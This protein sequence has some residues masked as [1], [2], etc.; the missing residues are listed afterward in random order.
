MLKSKA[1]E[2]YAELITGKYINERILG[3]EDKFID[4][5]LY[6]EI[7]RNVFEYEEFYNVIGYDL[8]HNSEHKYFYLKK[9]NE[10]EDDEKLLDKN[11]IK[12][13]VLSVCLCRFIMDKGKS[14]DSLFDPNIGLSEHDISELLSSPKFDKILT[15]SEINILS[16]PFNS[17]FE[18]KN[19]FSKN[20]KGNYIGNDIFKH[21]VN[22]QEILGQKIISQE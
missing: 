19:I 21:F 9:Q 13:Y 2:I 10:A 15:V 4:S 5:D 3:L 1:T 11:L 18:R 16:N 6:L 20:S 14:I 8:V 22:E 7:E 12:E 17:I